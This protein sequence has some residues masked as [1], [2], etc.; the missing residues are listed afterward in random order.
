MYMGSVSLLANFSSEIHI[1]PA[2][3]I[4]TSLSGTSNASWRSYP[5]H[6]G[7]RPTST[8]T[9]Y[10]I[11]ANGYVEELALPSTIEFQGR[12]MYAMNVKDKFALLKDVKPDRFYNILGEVVQV[13]DNGSYDC[14]TVHLSDY[15]AN[16][17]FYNHAWGGSPTTNGRDGDEHG[18]IKSRP[19]T[20]KDWPGPYGKMS[21]QL[22]L[23]DGHAA[24]VRE[25]VK[26]KEWV[27]LR[28]VQIKYGN[29]GG[30][31]EG[32]LRGDRHTFE[33]KVQ[34]E[35]M[36]QSE[37][38][39]END[40]RWK[41]AVSRKYQW[42]K[43]FNKE[44][45][46]LLDEAAGK[47]RKQDDEPPKANSKTRRKEKRAALEAKMAATETKVKIKLDLNENS[48]WTAGQRKQC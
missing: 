27:L 8:E 10:V 12:S 25:Q 34:V 17:E 4:P 30:R 47:K 11:G 9:A 26:D 42:E 40:S 2:S 13:Y 23:F 18:Y 15:T 39:D 1:L 7:K 33:G 20:T 3:K 19:K 36:K 44:K 31:L 6:K 43:K 41:E 45:Q 48:M 37:D 38:P 32:F 5:P 16:S 46:D 24:F 35:V 14:L 21:I 22:T 29:Q 28:N